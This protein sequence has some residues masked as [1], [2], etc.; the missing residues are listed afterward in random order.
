MSPKIND[1]K[2]FFNEVDHK[3][4]KSKKEIK[5]ERKTHCIVFD[6][7]GSF[8]SQV[9]PEISLEPSTTQDIAALFSPAKQWKNIIVIT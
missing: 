3:E 1:L 6:P 2:E 5:K 7:T 9:N 8:F 4:G